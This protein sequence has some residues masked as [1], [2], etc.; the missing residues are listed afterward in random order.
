MGNKTSKAE[1]QATSEDKNATEENSNAKQEQG[2]AVDLTKNKK[3]LARIEGEFDAMDVNKNGY[4]SVEEILKWSDNMRDLCNV[5]P[6][7]VDALHQSLKDFYGAAGLLPGKQVT[8]SEFVEGVNRLGQAELE[9]K[10]QGEATLHEKL[11]DAFYNVMDINDDGTVSIDEVKTIVKARNMNEEK[12][13]EWFNM[14]DK[15]K[16]GRVERQ[17]MVKVEFDIWFRPE[18]DNEN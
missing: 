7:E 15:N 13:E 9:R 5:T 3:W 2:T 11:C 18:D 4:V 12:A 6:G 14:A 16:S 17:E 1:K 10:K 8:K